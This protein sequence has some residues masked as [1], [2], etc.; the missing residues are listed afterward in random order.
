MN[1][2]TMFLAAAAAV[3]LAASAASAITIDGSVEPAYGSPR[4]TQTTQTQFGDN[5][6]GQVA[7]ANGSELDEAYVA[8]DQ[9]TMYLFLYG[10][11]E[12]NYNKLEIFFDSVPGGQ[13][14]LRGDNA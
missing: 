14:R 2:V 9:T 4:S 13:N 10:N 5:N 7:F 12:S 1:K 3:T 8:F 6:L 11:L